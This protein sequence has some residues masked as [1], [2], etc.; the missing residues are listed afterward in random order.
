MNDK[1]FSTIW[2]D[3]LKSNDRDAF[4]S[5]WTLSSIWDDDQEDDI[6][7]DRI[8]HLLQIWNAAHMSVKE[9]CAAVKLTQAKLA[10][11][12]CIPCRTVEDWCRGVS[13]CADYIRLM[14]MENLGILT[15]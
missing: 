3:A 2:A 15:R 13:K 4:V 12:F 8:E 1:I 6:P 14:M 9:I 7:Q 10:T 5:D 11:R